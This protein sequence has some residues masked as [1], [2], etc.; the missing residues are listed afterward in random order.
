MK[1]DSP[2]L[3]L[4]RSLAVAL[5]IG[6]H[7]ALNLSWV[8]ARVADL[9]VAG[10]VGVAVFFV[11]T[12]LVL[13]QSLLRTGASPLPFYVRR[14]FRIY[15]LSITFVLLS[16]GVWLSKGDFAGLVSNLFLV[17]NVTGHDSV[18][19]PLWSLPYE[20]QMYL[21]LPL[22]FLLSRRV[23]ASVWALSVAL[24]LVAWTSGIDVRIFQYLPCFL[25]GV[26]A[27]K[28]LPKNRRW[29]PG[30]MFFGLAVAAIIAPLLVAN[31]WPEAPILWV[32]CLALGI[33]IP[34]T[35]EIDSGGFVARVARVIVTYSYG[36]YVAHWL[37]LLVALRA[38]P[39][40]SDPVI[41][42]IFAVDL[43]VLSYVSYRWI[44]RPGIELGKRLADALR[45]RESQ[46][47]VPP[48]SASQP[49]AQRLQQLFGRW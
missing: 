49:P 5:V 33:A 24:I 11:H 23:V 48:Q 30:F 25:P 6:S 28:L 22:L 40:A 20:M 3:D 39:D 17:Q 29:H 18:P 34:R 2:N 43:G 32:L 35:R 21:V 16:A 26:M 15:P 45:A 31:G 42:A 27:S 1:H 12:S 9:E 46:K 13:M 4:L 7:L 41:V 36:A 37:A 10:R 47:L 8:P 19:P 38:I 14:C 44:E